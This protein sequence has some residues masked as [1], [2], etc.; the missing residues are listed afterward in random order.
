MSQLKEIRQTASLRE[1]PGQARKHYDKDEL[2]R[3]A[4]SINEE[5]QL[6][7]ILIRPDGTIIAGHRRYRAALLGGI[8]TLWV[9]VIEEELTVT[10]VRAIQL[11]ENV[12]RADL[13]PYEK[14]QACKELLELNGWLAKDLAEH[15]HLD[16]STVT[17][18]LSPSRCIPEAQEALRVG[19]IGISDAYAISKLPADD[20]SSLLQLKL[21][22]ASRDMLE[23]HGRKK[24]GVTKPAVRASKIKVPLVGGQVVA[25]SGA[26]VS[27][28]EALEAVQDAAKQIR[29]AIAKGITAKSAQAYWKD[30]AASG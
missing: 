6:Q 21:E 23:K 22:G 18:L 1:D 26:E 16:P 11:T 30:L 28:E 17:R 5:G 25:V 13:L 24:R 8:S 4:E 19:R 27:M 7:P 10:Q 29:A 20:Q 2:L 15:L 12:H 3:L 14:W 9:S